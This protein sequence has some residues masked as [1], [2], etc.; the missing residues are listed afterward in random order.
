MRLYLNDLVPLAW[1]VVETAVL[2]WLMTH[3]FLSLDDGPPPP[4]PAELPARRRL[5]WGLAALWGTDGLLQ[6]RPPMVTPGAA[7]SL[8][9]AALQSRPGI[10]G[11]PALWAYRLWM[12][13]PAGFSVLL[14]LSE[15]TLA[16]LLIVARRPAAVASVA[17]LSA[18]GG[19]FVWV[20]AETL[21]IPW[22]GGNWLWTGE[23]GAALLYAGLSAALLAPSVRWADGDILRLMR[24]VAGVAWMLGALGTLLPGGG[25]PWIGAALAAGALVWWGAVDGAIPRLGLWALLAAMWGLGQH[26]GFSGAYATDVQAAPAWAVGLLTVSGPPPLLAPGQLPD[27]GRYRPVLR[28][29]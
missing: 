16:T 14:A 17:A 19:M 8:W 23:P 18:A 5:R 28:R 20:T 24:L 27:I 12:T 25:S 29:R 6:F 4:A 21:G 15:L 2:L 9:G 10:V 22:T 3:W 11:E 13:D 26:F 7:Q 1:I